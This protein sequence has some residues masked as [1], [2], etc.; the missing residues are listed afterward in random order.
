M[1]MESGGRTRAVGAG[2]Y[3][4]LFQYTLGTWG[5][6]WNPWRGRNVF[7]GSAQIEASAYAVKK[8]KGRSLW[9]NTYPAA[10]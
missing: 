7:D 2:Q 6:D 8:G 5:G 4:G 10:F 3:Y 1:M 9:G